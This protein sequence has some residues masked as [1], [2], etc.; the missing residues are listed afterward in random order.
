M[1]ASRR[2]VSTGGKPSIASFTRG[3]THLSVKETSRNMATE[4]A[5]PESARDR[6]DAAARIDRDLG[7]GVGLHDVHYRDFLAAAQPVDWLE[8]H[9]ENYLGA[10]G[11]DLHVLEQV[12]RD[13]PL[14]FHGVGLSIGSA[15]SLDAGHLERVASLVDRFQPALVSEHLSWSVALTRRLHESLPLPLTSESLDLVA[16]NVDHL[17]HALKRTVL[18]ENV[19]R[20]VSFRQDEMTET[21]FIS[22]LVGRT[23]CALLVDVTSLYVNQC[24]H[25]D[26]AFEALGRFPADAVRELHVRAYRCRHHADANHR[27]RR[28]PTDVWQLYGY[29]VERFGTVSTLIECDADVPPIAILLDEAATARN[30]ADAFASRRAR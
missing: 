15:G 5:L 16:R 30:V 14:S 1:S 18:I 19:A 22:E 26:D 20:D 7:V 13:Y 2:R 9:T 12:R 24:N 8:V 4:Q 17:Q 27:G 25:G 28:V 6:A 29:A 11:Y 3:A 21:D 23:G 10:G